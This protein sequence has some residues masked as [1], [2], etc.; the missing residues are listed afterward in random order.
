MSKENSIALC[1]IVKNEAHVIKDTLENLYSKIKFDYWVISDT[2][3]TDDTKDIIKNFFK[4]KGI[5]GE[6]HE[7]E[8]KDFGHNRSLVFDY[9]FSAPVD[10]LF[11]FDA[12]DRINGDFKIGDLKSLLHKTLPTQFH[13][14][15][16]TGFT[17]T[18]PFIFHNDHKWK[19]YGVLHEYAGL[20]EEGPLYTCIINGNYHVD[21]RREGSRSKDPK[22]YEK[23]AE[24]LEKAYLEEVNIEGKFKSRYAFYC[25]NSYKDCRNLEKAIE[26]YK[27]RTT[28]GNYQE[29]VYLSYL[30]GARC[31]IAS[32]KPEDEIEDMLLK[33]WESMRNRSECLFTLANYLRMKK[34]YTKAYVFAELGAK[35]PFPSE[36]RLFVEKD[37]FEFKILDECA[38]SAF[39]TGRFEECFKLNYKLLQKNYDE[40]LVKN[41]EFCLPHLKEKAIKT[42]KYN[43]VKPKTRYYGITLTMTSCKRYDLFEQTVNSLLNNVK[44]IYMIER[45]I[46]IDDNSS[47]EDRK[48]ML[49]NYPF[50]E[51]IFKKPEEKGHVVSM[52]MLKNKLTNED[53]YIFHLE[54]DWVFLTRKNYIAKSI[55]VLKDN[56]RVGQV[57][58]NRNYAENLEQYRIQGGHSIVNNKFLIH[59]YEP[60]V[61]KRKHK[62]SCEYWPHF[63]FR[64]SIIKKEILDKI[65]NFEDINHFE[66]NYAKRFVSKNYMSV[67]YNGVN[68]LHIGRLVNQSGD[69]AY[70]LNG[71]K[72]F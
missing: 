65:G 25:A 14:H 28:L 62:I 34:K 7:D 59:E 17:Y 27:I 24:I 29:E 15:I 39:Y 48:K 41:M 70:S 57:L 20:A 5:P 8:W 47:S 72:Q 6:L 33:G 30:Y 22:K 67:F 12:D 53:K 26:Y 50:F 1:M 4:D 45:F 60:N 71:V 2:G 11:I 19:F 55:R 37:V 3:S 35:I 64:P 10:F 38:I 46:C 9:A 31:M 69:N 21:S 63:S 13:L 66:M 43:F 56:D 23:D 16:G 40:R 36:C 49:Y 42:A 61:S 54:D 32:E 58:F 52:N 44:D 68:T 18:R 51:F